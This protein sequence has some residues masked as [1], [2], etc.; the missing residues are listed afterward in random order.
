MLSANIKIAKKY[1]YLNE[2]FQKAYKWLEE[3]DLSSLAVGKYPIDGDKVYASV[4]EYETQ[5]WAERK[6][7]S[8]KKYFGLQ[9][10]VSG[11]EFFG[12]CPIRDLADADSYN[13]EKDIMFYHKEP[14]QRTGLVLKAGDYAI[15]APEDGH[16]PKAAV[17]DKPAHVKKIVI[18][19]AL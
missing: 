11:E 19:V 17:L 3:N 2:R 4:Q 15:V 13:E 16:K 10:I 6:Y 12:I 8:H 7:E 14:E 5:P 1:D 18:K 9:Y